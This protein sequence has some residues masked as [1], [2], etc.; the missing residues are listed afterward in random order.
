M[1]ILAITAF[2]LLIL[3]SGQLTGK[4]Q[5]TQRMTPQLALARI[6]ASEASLQITDDC[7]AIH[8]V[9]TFRSNLRGF[10][11]VTFARMYSTRVFDTTRTDRRAWISHLN[12]RGTEPTHWPRWRR[13]RR[14]N[15]HGTTTLERVPH[16][17]W[18]RLRNRWVSL[19]QHA[20]RIIRGEV[21]NQC[22]QEIH[23]WGG[24][25]DTE[26]YLRRNPEAVR[27]NCGDTVNTFWHLPHRASSAQ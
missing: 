13:T 8:Q 18:D 17:A 21:T 12:A 19:Y 14:N 23:D 11:Y 26:R 24:D 2:A 9:L 22:E 15:V 4:A 3:A 5:T 16:P 1:R 6:C 10:R 25:M 20:G 7:A 27:V